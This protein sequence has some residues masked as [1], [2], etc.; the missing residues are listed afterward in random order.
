M[1][2]QLVYI[3]YTEP[4]INYFPLFFKMEQ[5]AGALN[6]TIP[7]F[8]KKYYLLF[9]YKKIENAYL[10]ELKWKKN[11]YRKRK[12]LFLFLSQKKK[13]IVVNLKMLALIRI[14]RKEYRL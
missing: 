10:T 11:P 9:S 7:F 5:L 2:K 1:M 8:E 14:L 3:V 4:L 6:C 13:N 12:I